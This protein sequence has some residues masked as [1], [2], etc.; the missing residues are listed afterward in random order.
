MSE[1]LEVLRV[2]Y[3]EEML[4]QVRTACEHFELADEDCAYHFYHCA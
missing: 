4:T 3:I 1:E 2:D